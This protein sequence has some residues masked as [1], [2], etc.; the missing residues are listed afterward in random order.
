MVVRRLRPLV[1]PTRPIWRI[2]RSTVQRATGMPSRL[3]KD[4]HGHRFCARP[5]PGDRRQVWS[6][7][8]GPDGPA[9]RF[10][11]GAS[12]VIGFTA[13]GVG[14]V[15]GPVV[16]IWCPCSGAGSPIAGSALPAPAQHGRWAPAAGGTDLDGLD[17]V[18]TLRAGVH[19][20]RLR[21]VLAGMTEG[22][23]GGWGTPGD[24][25]L[26]HAAGVSVGLLPSDHSGRPI[27]HALDRGD[28]PQRASDVAPVQVCVAADEP[29]PV[30]WPPKIRRLRKQP[31]G[32]HDPRGRLH[33]ANDEV[34]AAVRELE[35]R[36]Q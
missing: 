16:G 31:V 12:G 4:A 24:A 3:L 34:V 28:E 9:H 2:S 10:A 35:G 8:S 33:L 30:L 7:G 15:V 21:R 18:A 25:G 19:K 13:S 6:T 27:D 26:I 20:A 32:P 36:H 11:G 17:R 22:R 5:R 29:S 23:S 14:R 1:R